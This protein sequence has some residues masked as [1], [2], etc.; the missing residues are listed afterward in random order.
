MTGLCMTSLMSARNAARKCSRANTMNLLPMNNPR[1]VNLGENIEYIQTCLRNIEAGEMKAQALK[2]KTWKLW[3]DN[4]GW[5]PVTYEQI[6][7]LTEKLEAM[8]KA[9]KDFVILFRDGEI[10]LQEA[11][12]V[13]SMAY[14][15]KH[16]VAAICLRR[17]R[18]VP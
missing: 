4:E 11:G 5:K 18:G 8:R 16:H 2:G 12:Y 1:T 9:D 3:T 10:V 6:V 15:A 7:N 14:Q 17:N 13:P